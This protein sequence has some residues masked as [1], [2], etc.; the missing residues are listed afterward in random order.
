MKNKHKNIKSEINVDAGKR[1]VDTLVSKLVVP[2]RTKNYAY[3]MGYRCGV[4]GADETNCHFSI[5]STPENTKEWERG[6]NDAE[7]C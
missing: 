1:Q 2:K 3:R 6:K 5:F 7:A 4:N